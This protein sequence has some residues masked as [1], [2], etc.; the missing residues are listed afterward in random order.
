MLDEVTFLRFA[1][2]KLE[3][4]IS[5]IDSTAEDFDNQFNDVL[6]EVEAYLVMTNG[7]YAINGLSTESVDTNFKK[8]VAF[9]KDAASARNGGKLSTNETV[10]GLSPVLQAVPRTQ[11]KAQ[12]PTGAEL[13]LEKKAYLQDRL[14]LTLMQPGTDEYEWTEDLLAGKSIDLDFRQ[15]SGL[16]AAWGDAI[17]KAVD[18]ILS[19]PAKHDG[20]KSG[21]D[22]P[23][24]FRLHNILESLYELL[25][26]NVTRTDADVLALYM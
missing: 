14:F 24:F 17:R 9:G 18:A 25:E 11:M 10:A 19:T 15:I 20:V 13:L 23:F 22:L 16:I 1:D 3:G 21:Y 5:K 2:R 12:G 4:R 6:D 26:N 8:I 7:S